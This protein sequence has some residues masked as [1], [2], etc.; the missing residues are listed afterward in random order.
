MTKSEIRALIQ[1]AVD[2]QT[3]F[4]TRLMG[5]ISFA[6]YHEPPKSTIKEVIE[7][8]VTALHRKMVGEK[9]E[10]LEIVPFDTSLKMRRH[11]NKRIAALRKEIEN[12]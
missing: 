6:K 7:E 2:N 5:S 8:S 4:L 11:L 9:I 1:N 10:E 3:D 12:G